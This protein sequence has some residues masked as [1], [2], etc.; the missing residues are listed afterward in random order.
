MINVN[1]LKKDN[2]KPVIIMCITCILIMVIV[3]VLLSYMQYKQYRYEINKS[4]ASLIYSILEKHPELEEEIINDIRNIDN[5]NSE[6][7]M[8]LLN[9]YGISETDLLY[10][11]NVEQEMKNNIILNVFIVTILGLMFLAIYFIFILIKDRKIEE[12]T[13]Y[14]KDINNNEY[15]LNIADNTEGELS[16]LRNEIYKITVMLREQAEILQ[17]DKTYLADSISDISHQ[18]KTP[19]TSISV[20]V[21]ILNEDKNIKEEKKNEFLFEISRQLEWINWL[22]ISLLKLSKLDAGAVEMKREEV[23]VKALINKVIQNLSIPIEIKN[24]KILAIGNDNV[25]FLGDFNWTLEAITNIT[26]NCL[27]HTKEGKTV[28]ILFKENALYTEILIK[29]EGEGI[30][31]E[32]LPHIFKRFYKGKNSNKDSVGIGLALAKSIIENQGGEILAKS[33]EGKGSEF[34]IKIYK[35]II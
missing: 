23:N 20:M 11:S 8:K 25:S 12:I 27:E 4:T 26:K 30:A 28:N 1:L 32:D 3:M 15:N 33:E 9:K 24:Q 13:T 2:V 35:G 16:D 22:V 17:K 5:Q 19:L 18:L 34:I 6:N 10:F 7:G 31:K 29:D 21:D 14:L